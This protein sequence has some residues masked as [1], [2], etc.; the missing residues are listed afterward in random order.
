M[1]GRRTAGHRASTTEDQEVATIEET[2]NTDPRHHHRVVTDDQTGAMVRR[3]DIMDCPRRRQ[4]ADIR[5][6]LSRDMGL[7]AWTGDEGDP[8]HPLVLL[9][10]LRVPMAAI[11]ISLVMVLKVRHGG[12]GNLMI[13]MR[14][15]VRGTRVT[16]VM[17]V[18]DI[19]ILIITSS[20]SGIVARIERGRMVGGGLRRGRGRGGMGG[21]G[22]GV[23]RGGGMGGG[24]VVVVVVVVGEKERGIITIFIVGGRNARFI[25]GRRIACCGGE[26]E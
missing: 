5:F 17:V 1:A 24:M 3:E 20:S 19:R 9:L 25:V 21:R 23:R 14:D 22:V 4:M 26:F 2:T 11:R 8:I 13:G 15:G 10:L 6:L 18:V 16:R 12:V 7:M